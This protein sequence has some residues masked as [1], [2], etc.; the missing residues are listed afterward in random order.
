MEEQETDWLGRMGQRTLGCVEFPQ[1]TGAYEHAP[2]AGRFRLQGIC[3]DGADE[4]HT[5][6]PGFDGANPH[7]RATGISCLESGV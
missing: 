7:D 2:G 5:I 3:G 1:P 4:K 6:T